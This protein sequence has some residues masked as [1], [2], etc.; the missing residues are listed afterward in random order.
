MAT[1]LAATQLSHSSLA[2]KRGECRRSRR[3]RRRRRPCPQFG[4]TFYV[5]DVLVKI[6][7]L[8]NVCI[9]AFLAFYL[10]NLSRSLLPS[11]S[12]SLHMHMAH[13]FPPLACH[14]N[15]NNFRKIKSMEMCVTCRCAVAIGR[16]NLLNFVHIMKPARALSSDAIA[17]ARPDPNSSHN[18]VSS[19]LTDA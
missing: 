15:V 9:K 18:K 4:R 13:L 11:L 10:G 8:L 14:G 3:R 5:P 19:D 12:L 1:S 6:S 17:E 16:R 2:P 7:S